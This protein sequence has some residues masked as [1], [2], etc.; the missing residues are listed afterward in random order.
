MYMF[1]VDFSKKQSICAKLDIDND[2]SKREMIKQI[3]K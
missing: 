3:K 2:S 1:D